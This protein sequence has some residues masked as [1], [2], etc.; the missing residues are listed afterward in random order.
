MDR[1]IQSIEIIS[2]F[3]IES[4]RYDLSPAPYV[5]DNKFLC[6]NVKIVF[7][8]GSIIETFLHERKCWTQFYHCLG[9][10]QFTGLITENGA[11]NKCNKCNNVIIGPIYI[12]RE[13]LME[14]A[15][16]EQ[17]NKQ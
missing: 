11:E 12:D 6:D 16:N 9:K 17:K 4:I 3:F 1:E 7:T 8:D 13:I 14:K 15:W 10:Y 2:E 5:P